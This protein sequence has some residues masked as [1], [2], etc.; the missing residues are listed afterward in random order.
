VTTEIE[1]G[2]RRFV[3]ATGAAAIALAAP[4]IWTRANA[5]TALTVADN[6]GALQPVMR[7]A[8]YDPFEKETGIHINNIAH[9][10][11]PVTQFKLSVDSGSHMWDVGMVTPDNV[12]RLAQ[13][14]NYLAPL[15]IASSDAKGI[16]PGM[17]TDTWL[18]FSIYSVIMGYR[19]D[20][21]TKGGPT[22]WADYW[23]PAKFPGRRGMYRSPSGTLENA[24]IAD[25][26][27]PKD[28]YPL[29]VDRAFK[30]LDKIRKSVNVW[31]ANGAQ[32]TQ[33]LQSGEV[34]LTDTWNS[35][36]YAAIASGAPVK[37]V[38]EGTYSVD[39]WSI[40]IGTPNLKAAQ[41]FV[42]F[43]MRADRQAEYSSMCFNGPSNNDAYKTI[44][45]KAAELMPTYPANLERLQRRDSA[46][47][48]KNFDSA[49][50]RYQE[51]LLNA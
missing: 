12:L 44:D 14:K 21:F 24:L 42:R 5:A 32:N 34:D 1:T 7:K 18:G 47:W 15:G 22:S 28:L 48:G 46:W 35:R 10:S 38:W 29:D 43:C 9:E 23:D 41:Q 40:P 4:T 39:G 50:E 30:S 13:P 37:L 31:W 11:D 19:S 8:F 36:A 33:L 17:L 25:G 49:N 6:G 27:A 3:K 26:V 20:K 45:K 51:W 16:L 2:R